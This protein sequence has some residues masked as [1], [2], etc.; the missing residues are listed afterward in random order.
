MVS[1]SPDP[2]PLT[3]LPGT[4]LDEGPKNGIDG[5]EQTLSQHDQKPPT[6][7]E[8]APC[9]SS[10]AFVIEGPEWYE[11]WVSVLSADGAPIAW[12]HATEIRF[13]E[14]WRGRRVDGFLLEKFKQER[15]SALELC[16]T[17]AWESVDSLVARSDR[18]RPRDWGSMARHP[19]NLMR[20]LLMKL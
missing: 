18:Y 10:V 20:H 7:L 5:P 15:C 13:E 12:G 11:A 4:L 14:V 17:K 16:L 8:L 19:R 1:L 9:H 3:P 2:L 6:S